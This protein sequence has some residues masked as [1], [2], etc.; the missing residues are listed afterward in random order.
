MNLLD[1]EIGYG[2]PCFVIAEIGINH[3]GS[4]KTAK[5]L[6]DAAN[7][8]KAEAVKFQKRTVDV[9]YSKEELDKP[10]D[11][12]FGTKNGHL[13]RALE[14]G[15]PEYIEIDA[16]C[17]NHDII[18]FA[19]PWD[20]QSVY[21]LEDMDV[22]CY[23]I[24]SACI[25]DMEL[26]DEVNHMRKPVFMSTGM[27]TLKEI[28]RGL[29]A[30]DKCEVIPMVTTSTYPCKLEELNLSRIGTFMKRFGK[31]VGYSGH[32][33]GIWTSYAAATMGA[34]VIERHITLDRAMWGSDQ[35]AS[36]EPHGIA[37]LVR[38]IRDLEKARGT[39]VIKP[40]KSEEPIKH[41]LRRVK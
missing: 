17:A 29:G 34:C 2:H 38:E 28:E 5:E 39:G 23:K 20:V 1:R 15:A 24:A 14:F 18:W 32:E 26:L 13:K 40:F 37:R 6:I 8:A 7:L 22:P 25:T 4:L 21:F 12:P 41:K 10:R 31:D 33:V 11:S 27:S 9:V 30:L 16:H 35:A 3:N 19:S 36:V